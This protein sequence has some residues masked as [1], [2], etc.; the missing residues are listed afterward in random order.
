VG[1]IRGFGGFFTEELDLADMKVKSQDLGF[2]LLMIAAGIWIVVVLVVRPNVLVGILC[3][4]VV[5]GSTVYG[6]KIFLRMRAMSRLKAFRGQFEGILRSLASGVRVGLGLHQALMLVAEEAQE[7]ARKELTRV[8]GAAN[9]G[10]GLFDA[11]DEMGRRLPI[12]ETQ[13]LARVMRVQAQAGGNLGEVLEGLAGTIRD[14]RRL[15]RKI[16]GLTAQSK[17]TSWL[18]GCLPLVVCAFML[19]TQPLMRT[20]VMTTPVGRGSMIAGIILDV[21]AV[22]VLSRMTKLDV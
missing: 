9:L 13:M 18:L 11:L 14:K 16:S 15:E 5:I 10:S 3:L 22:F 21:A 4:P 17:A 1:H 2:V 6:V 19:L 8:I 12:S 7:P 20:A